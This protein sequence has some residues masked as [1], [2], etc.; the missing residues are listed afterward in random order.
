MPVSTIT[1]ILITTI[2]I[3]ISFHNLFTD[4]YQRAH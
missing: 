4:E 3:R 1:I 2:G